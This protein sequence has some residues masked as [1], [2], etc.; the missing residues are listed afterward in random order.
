MSYNKTP[1]T[2]GYYGNTPP[3]HGEDSYGGGFSINTTVPDESIDGSPGED[4]PLIGSYADIKH[5]KY[6]QTFPSA[7]RSGPSL[8]SSLLT[9]HRQDSFRSFRDFTRNND[10]RN[11]VFIM[12]ATIFLQSMGFS[13]VL[14]SLWFYLSKQPETLTQAQVRRFSHL[15]FSFFFSCIPLRKVW[16]SS[17]SDIPWV[18]RSSLQFRSIHRFSSFWLVE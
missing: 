10:L 12:L 13:I 9:L 5:I 4:L 6:V 17:T 15:F 7:S 8:I 18:R 11:S 16:A 3:E 2:S 1:N 14:P